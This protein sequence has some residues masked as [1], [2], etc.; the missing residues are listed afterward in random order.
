MQVQCLLQSSGGERLLRDRSLRLGI[1]L[2]YL[3]LAQRTI[4]VLTVPCDSLAAE[5]DPDYS[6]VDSF[7]LGGALHQSWQEAVERK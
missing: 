4:G 3:H 7:V 5:G 2:R 6:A 1:E